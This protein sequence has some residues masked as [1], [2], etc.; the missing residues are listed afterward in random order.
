MTSLGRSILVV[1]VVVAGCTP[2]EPTGEPAW[3]PTSY[4]ATYQETRTCRQ[5]LEHD[6]RMR[7]LASPDAYEPF[8]GRTRAFPVGSIVL[9]EQYAYSDVACAGAIQAYTVM[10]KLDVGSSPAT[11]DWEWQEVGKDFH[12]P[13]TADL[14]TCINCHK[15]CGKA[16]MGYD[17]TCAEP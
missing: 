13:G 12:D 16:P 2:S 9:K 3:F 11:L 15:I 7:I 10:R 4:R 5:S 17:G 14:E 1:V 6:A 8:M